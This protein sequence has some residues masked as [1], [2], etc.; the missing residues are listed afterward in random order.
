[1]SKDTLPPIPT[2]PGSPRKY[3]L[4]RG[5]RL[6]RV[7][8][9]KFS[10][11]SF[12]PTLAEVDKGGGRF[13]AT[14]EDRYSFLY[15]GSSDECA[16]SETLLRDYELKPAGGR[17]LPRIVIK[18]TLI[19]W[20]RTTEDLMLVSIQDAADF[21]ALQLNPTWLT[22]SLSEDYAHTRRW[23]HAIRRWAPWAQGF[24][25]IS[26][27]CP[28]DQ[29]FVFFGDRFAAG[30]PPLEELTTAVPFPPGTNRLDIGAAHN[31]LLAI[32]GD[33]RFSLSP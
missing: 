20:V 22:H 5:T 27:L 17:L 12:N 15:A 29:A 19:S 24:V 30:S 33:L 23:G 18:E 2:T 11:S 9:M 31:H 28:P 25:W 21:G 7:H 10:P 13:D 1:M 8:S 32:L 14:G 6:T 4:N 3:L 26:R 16:V